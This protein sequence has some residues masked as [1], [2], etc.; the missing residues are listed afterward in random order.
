VF[1]LAENTAEKG[2]GKSIENVLRRSRSR[3]Q[4]K[5]DWIETSRFGKSIGR[6]VFF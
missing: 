3:T 1:I 2:D 5:K 6:E 4:V